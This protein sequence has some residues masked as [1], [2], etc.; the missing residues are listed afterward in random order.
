LRERQIGLPG[1]SYQI[2]QILAIKVYSSVN[3]ILLYQDKVYPLAS[4]GDCLWPALSYFFWCFCKHM[5][6][7][8]SWNGD[9]FCRR[10]S[11]LNIW[12]K[13]S[14]LSKKTDTVLKL[15]NK[16]DHI[17]LIRSVLTRSVY[18][19]DRETVAILRQ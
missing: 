18:W 3:C 8:S 11:A 19:C 7:H 14:W 1:V 17:W 15:Y 9:E 2:R 12:S 5:K 16:H 4:G 6:S 13:K 10:K